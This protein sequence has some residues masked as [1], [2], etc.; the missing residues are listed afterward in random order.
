MIM[1]SLPGDQSITAGAALSSPPAR[2]ER[3]SV[4]ISG[5]EQTRVRRE[6]VVKMRAAGRD[7]YPLGYP[8]TTSTAEVRLAHP[9]LVPDQRSGNIVGITGRLM[10]N[11]IGGKLCFATLQD[12]AGQLQVML[13]LDELGADLLAQWKTEVDLGDQ[14]GVTGEVVCSRRGE[15]SVMATSFAIT[16]KCLHPL[17]DKH[18]GLT[19]PELRMRMRYLDLLVRPQARQM[20][21]LRPTAVRSV[22]QT[23]WDK[24]FTEVET[25]MLQ[26]LHGGANARPFVTSSNAYDIPLFLR[27]APE[28]YLKRLLVGGAEQ[29]F[30]LNRNFR[31]EGADSSH[32]PEFTMLEMYQA[33]GDYNT[34]ADLTRT[35]VLNACEA[36]YGNHVARHTKEDSQGELVTTEHDLS[37]PWPRISVLQGIS[38]ALG[39]QVDLDTDVVRLRSLADQAG[40]PVAPTWAAAQILL[41]MYEHLLEDR[42][43]LPTFYY[44]FP[45]EVCPLT[46]RHRTTPE[47]AE[48]WDLVAFGAEI[49][50]GYSELID[51]DDQ[52]TRFEAQALLAAGGD[53]DAMVLDEDFIRALEHG[54][55]PSGGQG[56]GIDRMLMMLTG[57]NIR[58]TVLFPLVRSDSTSPSPASKA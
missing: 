22:R 32:N 23:L 44:D 56:M 20:L 46:R 26:V 53:V 25:P 43:G 45:A 41:E 57:A 16:S 29:I 24:G 7:P 47:L 37:V 10:L 42:T 13:S 48:R 36:V 19:D 34:M 8:R 30:E 5:T 2:S 35:I 58:E 28:L 27:I 12:A 6:K 33:Y 21:N 50:T 39:E 51:P 14:I 3:E 1:V 31:N 11:R 52:R 18:R 15:L 49:G 40:V 38:A 55:P 17:P 9:D 4:D 54:M